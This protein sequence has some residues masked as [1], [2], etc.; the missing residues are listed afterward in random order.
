[1]LALPAVAAEQ[2]S[3]IGLLRARDL[4]PFGLKRLRDAS[5]A[6]SGGLMGYAYSPALR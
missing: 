5:G 4:T 2:R 6:L 3:Y 1:M